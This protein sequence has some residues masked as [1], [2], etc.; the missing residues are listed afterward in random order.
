MTRQSLRLRGSIVHAVMSA[1]S[2]AAA[3]AHRTMRRPEM[4]FISHAQN[5]ED[6]VLRRGFG[7]VTRGTY[8]DIGAAWPD[9][10]SVT[11]AFYENNWSGVNVEPNYVLHE[12]LMEKRP[13]DINLNALVGTTTG[14]R[15]FYEIFDK[16]GE[17][18]G[19]S[20]TDSHIAGSWQRRGF[21][22]QR[23][24]IEQISL[25]DVFL[26]SGIQSGPIEFLK[27]DAEGDEID[28]LRSGDWATWRPRVVLCE[29]S[30]PLDHSLRAGDDL[31]AFMESQ[32]YAMR[33]FDGL[34]MFFE[35]MTSSTISD[36][37]PANIFDDYVSARDEQSRN[38]TLHLERAK[39]EL[40]DMAEHLAW[41]ST[42]I[43]ALEAERDVALATRDSV[44]TE[45]NVTHAYISSLE[46][47][48]A[49]I[50]ASRSWRLAKLLRHARNE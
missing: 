19:L 13:R 12:Q 9:R 5:H 44:S 18:T 7:N 50:Q 8:V 30:D 11:L 15:E 4:P 39:I 28:I 26:R 35:D 32:N 16:A 14:K 25:A 48:L 6:V 34:N 46:R 24:E 43:A 3:A 2:R 29:A 33:L 47:S 40:A 45:L 23:R 49:E 20:A 37:A 41:T 36:W 21:L 10:D 1:E 42:R 31:V 38:L 27:I 22:A 17:P